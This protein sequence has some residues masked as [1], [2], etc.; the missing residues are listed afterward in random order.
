MIDL[1][2]RKQRGRL[3]KAIKSSREAMIPYRRI[4]REF[5]RDYAGSWYNGKLDADKKTLVNLLNQTA[6][7]YTVA[8]AA[9]NP[10]VNVTTSNLEHWAEAKLFETALNKR[11]EDMDLAE[12]FQAL[13]LDAFFMIGIAAV[14]MRD[15]G[16]QFHGRLESEE[17]VFFDPGKP[18][19]TRVSF[20]DAILDMTARD[21]TK[22][23]F[24]GHMYRADYQKVIKERGY[25]RAVRTKVTPNTQDSLNE[26]MA[27]A[28]D[29]TS[30]KK[31]DELKEMVWLQDLWIPENGTVATMVAN[32]ELPPLLERPWT[33]G[34][35]GP[36]KF[37]SLGLMPDGLI[38]SSP[39]SNLKGLHD[40]QNRLH[41]KLEKQ[42]DN[43]K[44]VN[45]FQKGDDPDATA[46]RDAKDGDWVGLTNSRD[47]DQVKSGGVD[48]GN[49]AWSMVVQDEYNNMAGNPGARAGLGAQAGTASQEAMIQERVNQQDADARMKVLK[50]ASE[51]CEAIGRLIYPDE[52]ND[53][54]WVHQ[55]KGTNYSQTRSWPPRDAWGDR[56]VQGNFDELELKVQVD[57]MLYKSAE[58]KVQE[59]LGTVSDLAPLWPMFQASGATL[60]PEELL[61]TIADLRNRPELKRIIKFVGQDAI[62]SNP[63]Q[64]TQSPVTRRETVR[65]NIPTGGTQQ[66]RGALMAAVFGQG[67]ANGDQMGSL[68]RG[69]A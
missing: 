51:C 3:N 15:K 44:T 58:Q 1:S 66:S 60:D 8:L 46:L 18:W 68:T 31:D 26:G 55:V 7:I 16:T 64:A 14:S 39:A 35:S 12:T 45:V 52:F 42:S 22:M 50:F 4:R 11:I 20:D 30:T 65:R 9:N 33:G 17:D 28:R 10:R 47:I 27:H 56:M 41:R 5:L 59:I 36:Y 48:S 2:D 69:P 6:K 19:L 21:L 61:D 54:S 25:N 40:E 37:L 38:P 32:T 13:V 23:R 49:Q 62:P 29:I 57:S 67:A 53:I 43:Q 34:Q 63:N 24:C